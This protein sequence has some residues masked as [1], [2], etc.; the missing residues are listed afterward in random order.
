MP[1]VPCLLQPNSSLRSAQ[2]LS[3]SQWKLAGI[4]VFVDTQR[5]CVGPHTSSGRLAAGGQNHEVWVPGHCCREGQPSPHPSSPL[6]CT[7]PT[8]AGFLCHP[9]HY[10]VVVGP[11][12][13]AM[14]WFIMMHQCDPKSAEKQ[15]LLS[16]CPQHSM[17]LDAL[18]QSFTWHGTVITIESLSP[19]HHSQSVSLCDFCGRYLLTPMNLHQG[20]CFL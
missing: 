7:T 11:A 15:L 14:T 20:P 9:A 8:C 5:N 16:P 13:T 18:K 3:S 2:S 1:P 12:T 4:H 10:L 6:L 19:L 17:H